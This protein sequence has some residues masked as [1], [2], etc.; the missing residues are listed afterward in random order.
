[1]APGYKYKDTNPWILRYGLTYNND[2]Q[3]HCV[4]SYLDVGNLVSLPKGTPIKEYNTIIKRINKTT[5]RVNQ[6]SKTQLHFT[7]PLPKVTTKGA[8][9]IAGAQSWNEIAEFGKSK[10][11]FFKKRLQ[12]LR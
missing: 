12:G 11:D 5:S 1:M 8:A 4:V 7:N 2:P 6:K 3:R 10:L 9:V